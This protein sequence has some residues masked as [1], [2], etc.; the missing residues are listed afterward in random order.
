MLYEEF[1]PGAAKSKIADKM[2]KIKDRM[3]KRKEAIAKAAERKDA[4]SV[5]IN[6]SKMD[7]DNLDMAKQKNKMKIVDLRAKKIKERQAK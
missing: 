5:D 7:N 6:K 1:D 2:A 3:G 4:I